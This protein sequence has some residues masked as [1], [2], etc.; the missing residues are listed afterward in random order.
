MASVCEL[1]IYS[2]K[3]TAKV[4]RTPHFYVQ[5]IHNELSSIF[6]LNSIKNWG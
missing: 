3:T 2:E 4:C 5:I 1:N 6:E